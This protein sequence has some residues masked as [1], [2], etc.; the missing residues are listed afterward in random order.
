MILVCLDFEGVFTSEIWINV[1]E[2]TGVSELRRTTRDEPD[3]DKLM[4]WRI[5]ILKEKGIGIKGIQEAIKKMGVLEGS[6]EFLD[7][8]RERTVPII[9]T[10]SFYEFIMPLAKMLDYPPMFCNN[11]QLDGNGTLTGYKLRQQDGKRKAVEKFREMG[12]KVIG[13]GDSYNDLTFL[14]KADAGILFRPPKNI[15]KEKHG[16]PITESYEELKIEIEKA[17]DK[18]EG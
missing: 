15:I 3:Y 11:I 9:L 17:M 16:F 14:E 5:G 8:L 10:D 7:W 18:L 4:K 12:F 1:A 2:R 13:I 6:K